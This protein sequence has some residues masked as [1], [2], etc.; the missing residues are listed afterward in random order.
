MP[1]HSPALNAGSTDVAETLVDLLDQFLG[2]IAEGESPSQCVAHSPEYADQLLP[3]LRVAQ[4]L[5]HWAS[6][7]ARDE[8]FE[9][10]YAK[11]MAALDARLTSRE[12]LSTTRPG[13][14]AGHALSSEMLRADR[15]AHRIL[16]L[17]E[18]WRSRFIVFVLSHGTMNAVAVPDESLRYELVA[19][20]LDGKLYPLTAALLRIWCHEADE[21]P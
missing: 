5:K 8:A 10:G 19:D 17:E 12:R 1:R 7:R 2:C 6:L 21:E 11:T 9:R 18:P 20:L 3:L 4:V 14:P 15:L 13:I 16:S